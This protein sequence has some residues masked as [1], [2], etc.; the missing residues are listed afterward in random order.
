MTP[1]VTRTNLAVRSR[2]RNSGITKPLEFCNKNPVLGTRLCCKTLVFQLK[3]GEVLQHS[4]AH[5]NH[6]LSSA[7]PERFSDCR[8]T[9]RETPRQAFARRSQKTQSSCQ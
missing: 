9:R 7:D 4:S 1:Q 5:L 6:L 2:L 8:Y 3:T